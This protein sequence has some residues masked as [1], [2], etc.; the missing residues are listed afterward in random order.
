[1]KGNK[2]TFISYIKKYCN[3]LV[4]EKTI[5]GTMF[6]NRDGKDWGNINNDSLELFPD[7]LF[8]DPKSVDD[9]IDFAEEEKPA[10]TYSD[11]LKRND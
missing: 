10:R 11:F 8:H 1:M 3:T 7:V 5:D 4:V 6:L 2:E 9:F